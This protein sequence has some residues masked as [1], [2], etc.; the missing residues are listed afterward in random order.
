M[1]PSERKLCDQAIDGIAESSPWDSPKEDLFANSC[2]HRLEKYMSPGPDK[3]IGMPVA[4]EGTLR[5]PT[6]VPNTPVVEEITDRIHIPD[7]ISSH[8]VSRGHLGSTVEQPDMQG[9]H[10][11]SPVSQATEP[12][13]MGSRAQKSGITQPSAVVSRR[14]QMRNQGFSDKLM[15]CIEK[16][17]AVST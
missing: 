14:E 11:A 2:N 5:I 12:T 8:M 3:R 15:D 9:V 7:P 10:H 1:V 17:R 16:S 4:D 6:D 13:A